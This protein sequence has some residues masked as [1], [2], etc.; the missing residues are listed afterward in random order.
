LLLT[1]ARIPEVIGDH[2]TVS[3]SLVDVAVQWHPLQ[4]P[5]CSESS[6]A[7]H[8]QLAENGAG[9]HTRAAV[10]AASAPSSRPWQQGSQE[11]DWAGCAAET[12][13]QN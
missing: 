10:A 3:S 2:T 4:S 1:V 11:D 12:R 7:A 13:W 9:C 5:Q 6:E 8:R